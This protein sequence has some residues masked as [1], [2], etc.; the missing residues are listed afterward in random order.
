M[1]EAAPAIDVEAFTSANIRI[2]IANL[3]HSIPAGAAALGRIPS[4]ENLE[5]AIWA[6]YQ[7]GQ[8]MTATELLSGLDIYSMTQR[9]VGH[10]F[11]SYNVLL[12]PTIAR[13]PC[14][15]GEFNA[16]TPGVSAEQW[17]RRGLSYTPFTSLF[18]VTG[19]PAV[20]VP[21]AWSREGLPI[22][23]QF[24]GRFADEATLFRLAGQLE[25][26]CPWKDKWPS[27]HV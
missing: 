14:P 11:E 17:L 22:G 10:F 21:L 26:A 19:Q 20:S 6:C 27:V 4:E 1:V 25:L 15:I 7:Y 2:W 18:N 3:S 8:S 5:A 13:P 24:V 16:N 23:M 9:S 12:T